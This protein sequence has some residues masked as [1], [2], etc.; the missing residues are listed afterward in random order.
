[1]ERPLS[2]RTRPRPSAKS[3]FFF[4]LLA[5]SSL[6][7]GDAHAA[8]DV[9]K[10]PWV[11]RV[12]SDSAIVRVEV[13][14]P[15]PVT[16]DVGLGL[17]DGEGG[18]RVVES[19]EPRSL[20]SIALTGLK[21]GTRYAYSVRAG[22]ASKFA[23]FVT[24][25]PDDGDAPFRFLVYGDNRT[26]HAAH[27]AVVRAMVPV[28]SDFL[29]H[30]GDFVENGASAAQWQ[31]FFDIEAPLLGS[32]CLFSSVGNHELTD[33]AGIEYVRFFGP[34]DPPLGVDPNRAGQGTPAAT[35]PE[36][37]DG[38]FR[39]GNTRFFFINGMV[40]YKGTV[41]RSWLE[42]A[43]AGADDENG[44]KWRVVV[45]HHGPWSSGPHGSNARLHDAGVVD[46]LKAHK[47]DLIL[48][49]HDHLYERGWAEGLAYVVSGGGGAPVYKIKSQL[50]L[51]RKLESV[52]HFVEVNVSAASMQLVATRSDGSTI[53][54]CALAKGLTGW[55]CDGPTESAPSGNKTPPGAGSSI[56]GT[57]PSP[58]RCSC[59]VVGAAPSAAA[60]MAGFALA[61]FAL[62]A[63]RR[64][65]RLR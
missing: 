20:H 34:T 27:A 45:T 61:G 31:K 6:E 16:L 8:G 50:P 24:A 36:H 59:D 48:S 63:A 64:R 53:E 40:S 54:R 25:P 15:G 21:P 58:S 28:A 51:A 11:Q 18:R 56:P 29:V 19:L 62:A 7:A 26:D 41:D 1:M 10:G 22:A 12:T 13:D 42:N 23:A 57:A 46:L 9:T 52:R 44:L 39:W 30:T 65:R 60:P 2:T 35:R 55:D 14:P 49:G 32:R 4:A 3:V 43:L 33:G 38:T 37:L 47:V 17:P 5:A